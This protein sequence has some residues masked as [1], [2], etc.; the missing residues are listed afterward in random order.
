ML[1]FRLKLS[2]VTHKTLFQRFEQ[3]GRI[4][5]DPLV[6]AALVPVFRVRADEQPHHVYVGNFVDGFA[7]VLPK[8]HR[9][10]L[11]GDCTRPGVGCVV[12]R[13]HG[14]VSEVLG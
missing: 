14:D 12:G 4:L 9:E 10:A 6:V 13:G 5:L 7:R 11:L 8:G 3:I 2:N 1:L